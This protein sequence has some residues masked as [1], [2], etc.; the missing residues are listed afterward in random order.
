M[1]FNRYS[2]TTMIKPPHIVFD[3][4]Q[5]DRDVRDGLISIP[6]N[7]NNNNSPYLPSELKAVHNATELNVVPLAGKKKV[8]IAITIA[9]IHRGSRSDWNRFSKQF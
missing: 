9:S 2:T 4:E 1:S 3:K 5:Y 8:V 7:L 6:R